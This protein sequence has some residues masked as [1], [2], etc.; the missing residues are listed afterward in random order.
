M[1]NLFIGLL[2]LAACLLLSKILWTLPRV[3]EVIAKTF[4][5][6]YHPAHVRKILPGEDMPEVRDWTWP[7]WRR[8][9][10][11]RYPRP[12][13]EKTRAMRAWASSWI[14]RRWSSPRKLSA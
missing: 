7:N 12:G 8:R 9:S 13:E 5:V 3:A 2:F 14:R 11:E 4:G 1:A 6:R 10:G